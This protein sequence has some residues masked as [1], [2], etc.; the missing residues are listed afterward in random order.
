VLRRATVVLALLSLAAGTAV[1]LPS[2]RVTTAG[3]IAITLPAHL[4]SS[5]EVKNQL[6][7]GL[8]TVFTIAATVT[9]E[10]STT[11]GGARIDVRF[12][13]WEEKYLVT[14]TGPAGDV[15]KLTFASD[16]ALAQWW[17][18]NAL[19]VTTPHRFGQRVNVSVKLKMLPFSVQ[20]QSDTQRWLS[21]TL[22]SSSTE[23]AE[24]SPSQSAEILR[25]IVETSVRRRPIL[26]Y[27]WSVRAEPETR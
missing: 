9:D 12:E 11:R 4:L 25:I 15:H 7:S 22:A 16:V 14:V 20:E 1:R 23:S 2:A 3:A 27:G 13:L 18:E 26:E 17:S 5:A 10:R 8:T 24:R 19:V 21:R 6:T